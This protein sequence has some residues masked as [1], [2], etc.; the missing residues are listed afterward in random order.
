MKTKII[1]TIGPASSDPAV[2]EA[3]FD[4]GLDVCRLNFSHGTHADHLQTIRRIT[5]LNRKKN[6][7]VAILADLQGP[8]IRTGIIS[9]G[10]VAVKKGDKIRFV[11]RKCTGTREKIYI[12]YKN[13]PRDVQC[14]ELI[15]VDDGNIHLRVQSTNQKDEVILEVLHGGLIKSHKGVNLPDTRVSLPGLTDKDKEDLRFILS[16]PVQWV[17]L[18]FVRSAADIIELKHLIAARK[19]RNKPRIIAKIEKPEALHELDHIIHEADGL[20]VARGDLGVELPIQNVPLLQKMMVKKCLDAGKPVII[21]TQM[22]ESMIT[23]CGPT[24]AEVN[25]VANSVMDGA[26]ACMLS[27]ET[28]VGAFPVEAVTMMS[29]IIQH[30][31]NFQD[32]Y[33]KHNEPDDRLDERYLTDSVIFNAC[34][35][36]RRTS[37]AAIV[38]MTHT[39][40]SAF[41]IASHRPKA[42]IFIFTNNRSL[43]CTLNLV[44]GVQGFYYDKFIS[45]DHTIED[46][47]VRLKS[48]GLLKDGDIVI[49]IASIPLDER[50]KTNM[51]KI[52][53]V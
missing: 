9:E 10:G 11:T 27:G 48:Q 18:S 49:N 4:A 30:V 42:G 52:S 35:L 36:A 14:G 23:N 25:D 26:D 33:Y 46:I 44:W 38:A 2:L 6:M 8:K 34:E 5:D 50:G 39:G 3:L 47:K 53:R 12:S 29:K 41:R 17:A 7:N 28:A 20:M 24:R 45:T 21:A 22:L 31:E 37:A 40:Y 51:L 15:L 43:L 13:F 1:A 19:S 16:H 32:I